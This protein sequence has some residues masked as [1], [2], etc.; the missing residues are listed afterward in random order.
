MS[1]F[2]TTSGSG[3]FKAV[4]SIGENVYEKTKEFTNEEKALKFAE[5]VFKIIC[6]D[7]YHTLK[8]YGFVSVDK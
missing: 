6:E 8:R 3:P 4:I 7:E 1:S 5:T 2:A